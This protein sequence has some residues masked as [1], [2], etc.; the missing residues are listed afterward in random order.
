MDESTIDFFDTGSEPPSMDQQGARQ[1]LLRQMEED[2]SL[3]LRRKFA[4]QLRNR[5]E[6]PEAP[7]EKW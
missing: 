1:S 2:P 6:K 3:F 4:H 5:K 7:D